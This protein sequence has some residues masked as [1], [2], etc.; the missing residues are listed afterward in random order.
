VGGESSE[1]SIVPQPQMTREELADNLYAY[2]HV[3]VK[4]GVAAFVFL[5]PMDKTMPLICCNFAKDEQEVATAMDII[6]DYVVNK[7]G[8]GEYLNI[9]EPKLQ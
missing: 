8:T 2:M 4:E 5:M 3:M 1:T 9:K 6:R 7:L